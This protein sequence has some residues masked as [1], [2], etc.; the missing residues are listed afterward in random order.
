MNEILIKGDS[1][2]LISFVIGYVSSTAITGAVAIEA[3]NLLS[4]LP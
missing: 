2:S 3:I 1:K 4:K